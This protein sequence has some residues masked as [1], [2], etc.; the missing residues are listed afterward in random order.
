MEF[1]VLDMAISY[2]LLLGRPWIHVAKAVPSSLHQMVKLEWYRQEI[3]VHDDENLCA[4]NGTS[5][6]FIDT[7]EDKGSWVYQ[8]SETV[9][10]E[11]IPKGE[12]IVRPKLA[13]TIVMVATKM[14]KNGFV[15]GK[16][17]GASLQ[18]I[19]HPVSLREN[20]G[21]F[22]LGFKSIGDDV[23]KARKLKKKAWSLRK[24]VPRLSGSFIKARVVK[25][26]VKAVPKPGVDFD[27]ELVKRFKSLSDEVN[28]VETGEEI[29]YDE[30]EAFE[31]ISKKLSHFEE[32]PKPNL[33][34]IE[35]I[36]LEDPDNIRE[37]KISVHLEPQIR[38]EIIK[39]LFE[40]KDIFAWSY[41]DMPGLS[42]DLV[43]HKLPTDPAFPPI[44]YNLK[45]NL[46]KCAL[47]VPSEKLL[48]FIFS[49]RGIE[50]DLS[51]IKA[52]QEL[53]PP[54]NKTEVMSLLRR[55][56]YINRF[57][58][59][60]I[61]TCEPIFKLL[62]KDVAVT[63]TDECQEAFDKIKGYN[64][65]LNLA[66]CALGVP[67]E[68]LLG[69]IF[70]RRGIELDLSKIKAIQELP[71]PRNKTEVMSLLRRLNY[72]NRFI[73]QLITT[74]EPIFKLL[75]KDVAV[76]WTDEC[77]EA[78]DKIKGHIPRT[79]NEVADALATLASMLYHPDKAYVDPL[80]IQGIHQDG[81]ISNKATGDQKR[82]IRC[83]ASGFLLSGEILYKRTPDLGL[84]RCIDAKQATTIMTEGQQISFVQQEPP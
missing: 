66:K 64:L 13:S 77:Q 78:F 8:V 69:F 10:V 24:P 25:R 84:L 76:T 56:N 37:T 18:G 29:E 75:K 49:R 16:G 40:C 28:T 68:K 61:T 53:P 34:E 71:P 14:L 44:K 51:K 80:D 1:Q 50:L 12:Y 59:Q 41:D 3:D 31:E 5:I 52:I 20:L 65:K 33:N 23:K 7:E 55:L 35:A 27:E 36:N 60:L 38:E 74:C 57:I 42:I 54:R 4:F 22:G 48:G 26:P 11:K 73:A 2:N 30:E 21:T 81:G 58:A 72:I 79:H 63:W 32:K 82:T 43:V 19:V 45:L 15:S 9:S 6:P 62:K 83:L 46:A 47:G 70:S 39:A 67:S 17:L